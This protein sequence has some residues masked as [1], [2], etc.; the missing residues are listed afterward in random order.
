MKAK[1]LILILAICFFIITN[2][3]AKTKVSIQAAFDR[4]YISA[5]AICKGGL[6]LNY[7]VSNLLQDSLVVIIPAG[8]R[9]NSD[10]G[11]NDYQDIL[12][13]R[14]E[15]LVLRGKESK[16]FDIKGYCC[17]ATKAGPV[18]G[19]KY[20]LGKMAD[21]SLVALA[22]YLSTQKFDSNTE[23]NSVWAISDNEST[24]NITSNND[25]IASLLRNYVSVLKGEPLP[26]YTLLKRVGVTRNG[27]VNNAPVRFKAN[28]NYSVPKPSYS[29]CYIVDEK[30]NKVSEIFG[31]WLLPENS[32]YKANFN[33]A[34]FKKGNYTLILENKDQQ[35]FEKTFKI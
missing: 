13:A 22:R 1:Y 9:F 8:W 14:P 16:K 6:E 26:W 15:L 5:K 21:S 30:G 10:A 35:L 4:K 18:E 17:E 27:T 12:V 2:A 34:G 7:A 23:Q 24:A 31:Q 3:V 11:K 20:T 32:D 19:A 25:S 28:I 33:V 29:Y